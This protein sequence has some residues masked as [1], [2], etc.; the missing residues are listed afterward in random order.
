MRRRYAN[1]G[2][3]GL[4]ARTDPRRHAALH[5]ILPDCLTVGTNVASIRAAT[6]AL[7]ARSQEE[8]RREQAIVKH[9]MCVCWVYVLVRTSLVRLRCCSYQACGL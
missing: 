9:T 4:F 5:T 8:E 1:A 3:R 6:S 2:E 7:P